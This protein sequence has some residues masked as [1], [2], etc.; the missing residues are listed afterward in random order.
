[1]GFIARFPVFVP[2]GALSADTPSARA[3]Q[4]LERIGGGVSNDQTV[5]GRKPNPGSRCSEERDGANSAPTAA[6]TTVEVLSEADADRRADF[7]LDLS[8]GD[9]DIED[10]AQ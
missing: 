2:T 9:L 3:G 6:H 4:S 5:G 7:W 8:R 10:D 1:M